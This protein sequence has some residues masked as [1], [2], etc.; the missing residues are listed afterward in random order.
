M[1]ETVI[2]EAQPG[3]Q[4]AFLATDADLAIYGGAAGGG[5]TWAA[6][7]EPLR[8]IENPRF[9][10]V[11][12]R[13]TY[14]QITNEGAL[15]DEATKLY[16]LLGA[17]SNQSELYWSFP[18]GASIS[19][20]HLQHEKD[21]QDYQGSQIALLVFD[22]LTHFTERQFFYML[23]RNRST[24][25][26]R[27]YVRGTTNPDPDSW[28]ASFIAWWIDQ[29]TGYPIPERAGVVRWFIRVND[30]IRWADDRESLIE[31]LPKS[32]PASVDPADVIKSATFIPASVHDNRILLDADP[33]YLANLYALPYVEREQLLGGNWKVRPAAGKIFNRGWYAV[34]SAAPAGGIECLFWDFA[35]TEKKLRKNDP[36]FTAGVSQR[37]NAGRL[38]VTDCLSFQGGP[39]EVERQFVN[40][41]RQRAEACR[42][43][44][45]RF[46]VRWEIEP[47][48][49]AKREVP[50]YAAMLA[51]LDARGVRS[52]GDKFVRARAFAAQ[53]EAGNVDLVRASW[54][55]GWLR[56]MH[57]QPDEPHDDIMD[58]SAGSFNEI[59]KEVTAKPVHTSTRLAP[60]A[61]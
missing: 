15:W 57:N 54:N 60:A 22:E 53:S 33:S 12:F 24:C 56:H 5:K 9:G 30:E 47:G 51:G 20:A 61:A 40:Y 25:G 45:T 8:H 58:A 38:A 10:A 13:R 28:V 31:F 18:S 19:F 41:S 49:A 7:F 59:A 39:A 3:P 32:L 4:S 48:S 14:P 29:D 1:V 55:E 23:S 11:V 52:E 44:G 26:V 50:R 16:P 37:W 43:T 35:G 42:R 21:V 27:P 46:M 36:D 34:V 6:L 17:K 2:L